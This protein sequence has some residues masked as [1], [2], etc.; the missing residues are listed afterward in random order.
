LS[1]S[2]AGWYGHYDVE[3]LIAKHGVD[4]RLP[5]LLTMLA[6]CEKGA[7][8]QHLDRCK[9]RFVLWFR[10]VGGNM[11]RA[12]AFKRPLTHLGHLVHFLVS[13]LTF[14]ARG[15]SMGKLFIHRGLL[16]DRGDCAFLTWFT[17]TATAAD[18]AN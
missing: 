13:A 6:N 7:L 3:R 11:R 15:R 4:M 2:G 14:M 12:K 17:R 5:E 8:V 9:A 18:V 1:A 10:R 16:A